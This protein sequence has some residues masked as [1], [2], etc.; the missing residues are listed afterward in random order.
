M[1]NMRKEKVNINNLTLRQY[2]QSITSNVLNV[3]RLMNGVIV[4]INEI[5]T[6]SLRLT[7]P[8][9]NIDMSLYE[10]SQLLQCIHLQTQHAV[11]Q[12]IQKNDENQIADKQNL[13]L[14]IHILLCIAIKDKA[15]TSQY[16]NTQNPDKIYADFLDK[17]VTCLSTNFLSKKADQIIM[18]FGDLVEKLPLWLLNCDEMLQKKSAQSQNE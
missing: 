18:E 12:K 11:W 2:L 10:F 3:L 8:S 5:K 15:T 16:P 7:L 17:I 9:S 6:N 1:Y 14:C 13:S 4:W